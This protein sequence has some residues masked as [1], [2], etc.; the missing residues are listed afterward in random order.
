MSATCVMCNGTGG[1]KGPIEKFYVV[2]Q[3]SVEYVATA[4]Y[5]HR[6]DYAMRNLHR[7]FDLLIEEVGESVRDDIP[8]D[9]CGGEGEIYTPIEKLQAVALHA[10][11]YMSHSNCPGRDSDAKQMV[12]DCVQAI[13]QAKERESKAGE[14]NESG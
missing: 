9:S 10:I 3:S 1:H 14:I 5:A 11:E 13:E 2:A 8:C 7:A 4:N 12:F 6:V